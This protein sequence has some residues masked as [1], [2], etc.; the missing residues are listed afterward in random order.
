MLYA[1]ASAWVSVCAQAEPGASSAEHSAS[2]LIPGGFVAPPKVLELDR[3]H[4]GFRFDP[5]V[6]ALTRADDTL[7]AVERMLR[8]QLVDE[9]RERFQLIVEIWA[10]ATRNP[11]IAAICATFDAHV[12]G[13]LT[14]VI[15]GAKRNGL[16]SPEIDTAFASL[17]Q[18]RASI[19]AV[20]V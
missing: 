6:F 9:S 12:Q 1:S 16:A 5:R 18:R 3:F 19:V 4:V 17:A 10:E 20:M 14:A 8:K 11:H 15:D 7:A 13:G 2:P